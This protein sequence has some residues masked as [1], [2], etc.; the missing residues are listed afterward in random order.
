MP[1]SLDTH[2]AGAAAHPSSNL[3]EPENLE[4]TSL[5]ADQGKLGALVQG[6]PRRGSAFLGAKEEGC[7]Q[8]E[9]PCPEV[10]FS[11]AAWYNA[12]KGPRS[13]EGVQAHTECCHA[14]KRSRRAWE[15]TQNMI[16]KNVYLKYCSFGLPPFEPLAEA[17]VR[18][19]RGSKVEAE[20]EESETDELNAAT[21]EV[22]NSSDQR[23]PSTDACFI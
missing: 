2:L 11:R 15:R 21:A 3:L 13:K 4:G 17:L 16:D 19:W 10:S 14:I 5:S 9:R 7:I 1:R 22:G 6:V 20:E 23:S 18:W 8:Q 12:R